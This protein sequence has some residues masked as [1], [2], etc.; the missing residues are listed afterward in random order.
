VKLKLVAVS[1]QLSASGRLE[2]T[3]FLYLTWGGTGNAV[4]C[5]G[6]NTCPQ[7]LEEITADDF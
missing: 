3:A 4:A 1:E 5:L 7:I 2:I 6:L